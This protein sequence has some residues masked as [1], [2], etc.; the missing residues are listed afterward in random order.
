ML[1]A[2]WGEPCFRH[3]QLPW[4]VLRRGFPPEQLG[5]TLA[6]RSADRAASRRERAEELGRALCLVLR[7]CVTERVDS[8]GIERVHTT[9]ATVGHPSGNQGAAPASS[10]AALRS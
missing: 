8:V 10:G 6:H 4:E 5:C 7:T 2:A 3:S 9:A 1:G